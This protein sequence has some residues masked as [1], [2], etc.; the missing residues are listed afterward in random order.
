MTALEDRTVPSF[1]FS[2]GLLTLNGDPF[3]LPSDDVFEISR[4]R[5]GTELTFQGFRAKINGAVVFEGLMPDVS[6]VVVNGGGRDDTLKVTFVTGTPIPSGGLT[7]NGGSGDDVLQIPMLGS[8]SAAFVG[9]GGIDRVEASTGS[10]THNLTL[11]NS[12]LSSSVGGSV[13]VNLTR[14]SVAVLTGGSGPNVLDA[15]AFTGP[16]TLVGGGGNDTLRGGSRGDVLEG[17]DD[18]DVMT[19]GAGDD[20]Y[21]FRNRAIFESNTE[22]DTIDERDTLG[23]RNGFDTLDFSSLLADDPVT[24]LLNNPL[25]LAAHAKRIVRRRQFR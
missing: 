7:F 24:V 19:G 17:G 23:S 14:V 20:R 9:G 12:R 18:D 1:T 11:T 5:V 25:Q 10:G 21:V 13:Q 15:S 22:T 4:F 16:V 2:N 8:G 3:L 6:Q